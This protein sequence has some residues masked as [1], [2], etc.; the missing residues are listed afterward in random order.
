MDNY[1]NIF[2]RDALLRVKGVGDV[3]TRADDFGMRIWLNPDK[4]AHLSLTPG[5]VIQAVQEQN[6]Q[7]AAGIVGSTPQDKNQPFEYTAF[8]EGRLTSEKAFGEIIVKTNP[9]DG[10]LVYLKDVA[11]VELGKFNYSGGSFVD[12][13]PSSFVL[14]F[15]LPGSNAMETANGVYTEMARLSKSFP[16]DLAYNVPFEAVSVVKVSIQEVIKTLSI[17]LLLVVLVVFIFLQSWRATVIPILAIPVSII[18]TFMF[19]GPLGFT[20]NTLTLF[21]LV[22]AIGI[23]VDDAII[24][25]EAIQHYIDDKHL[26]AK[27]AS[28]K[29]MQDISGPVV[30]IALILAAVFVPVGFYSRNCRKTLPAICNNHCNFSAAFSICSTDAY[31]GAELTAAGS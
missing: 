4:M 2:V 21:G 16:P 7:V 8:V 15:Q 6:V 28:F 5:D 20:I 1:T 26:T 14:V 12:G 23:V 24:V 30:A 19:F 10:S 3:F 9:A 29:A 11:R 17:A 18:G 13:R 25:V 22:M 27:E 31:P